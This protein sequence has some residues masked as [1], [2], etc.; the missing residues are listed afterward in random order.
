M[1]CPNPRYR[2]PAAGSKTSAPDPATPAAIHHHCQETVKEE[3]RTS[4]I[5]QA[6][7][8][9]IQNHLPPW[10]SIRRTVTSP[11][12]LL[13]RPTTAGSV[14]S[15]T[16]MPSGMTTPLS[17]ADTLT[18]D[19]HAGGA[20]C[21]EIS[22]DYST[23]L[24]GV[25]PPRPTPITPGHSSS[26]GN[27]HS[28]SNGGSG[29]G[30]DWRCG[31]LGMDL[32]LNASQEHEYTQQHD[33]TSLVIFERQAYLDGVSYLLK[34]LP[35]NLEEVEVTRLRNS[36]PPSLRHTDRPEYKGSN[37]V[38]GYVGGEGREEK[39]RKNVV[40]RGVLFILVC[41]LAWVRW[42]APYFFSFVSEM[43]RYERE[44][45][46]S[47]NIFGTTMAGF[48]VGVEAI[49]KLGDGVAGQ[50]LAGALDYTATGV[51]GALREFAEGKCKNGGSGG[52]KR[53]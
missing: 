11:S 53:R 39:G 51:S 17:E 3:T 37:G 27:V 48:S 14:A 34:G 16:P 8:T 50:L 31:Q 29:S 18:P 2:F 28:G 36:L 24:S 49:R 33:N 38:D 40:H 35:A 21:S 13:S 15:T 1:S 19:Y 7:P 30:V 42:I 23:S 32:L 41:L 26:N 10:G 4:V 47:N 9:S 52:T 45:K 43:M 25:M 46:V 22:N 5:Y 44:Y 12:T 6:L 20:Y